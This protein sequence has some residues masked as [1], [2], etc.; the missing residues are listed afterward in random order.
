MF[1]LSKLG[2]CVARLSGI[3]EGA[4]GIPPG[5]VPLVIMLLI[6]RF[7]GSHSA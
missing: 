1:G 2:H 3:A 5:L 4:E 6:D 7:L